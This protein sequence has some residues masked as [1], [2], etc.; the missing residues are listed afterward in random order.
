MGLLDKLELRTK[1]DEESE[2]EFGTQF[3]QDPEPGEAPARRSTRKTA[4]KA[5][6]RKA[7]ASVTK[8]AKEVAEDL[9]SMLEMTAAVWG[10]SDQCCA[11]VLEQQ[12]RPIADAFTSILARNP[13]LLAKFAET[14]MIAYTL[15]TAALGRALAPLGKAI[16]S[17]HV[18]K[19][20]DE[21]QEQEHTE[22]ARA[23]GINLTSFPTFRPVPA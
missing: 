9:A 4:V 17:N 10:M 23:G 19:A 12:A 7:T 16:Y 21:D 11:P 2:S 20:Y 13:R 14:D 1:N 8:M 22:H 5:A 18:S 3:E 6:P 15:Q